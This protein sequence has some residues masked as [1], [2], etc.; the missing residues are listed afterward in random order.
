M[1]RDLPQLQPVIIDSVIIVPKQVGGSDYGNY[2]E[3]DVLIDKE[4]A[5]PNSAG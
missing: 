1:N 3:V 4:G 2:G 5:A